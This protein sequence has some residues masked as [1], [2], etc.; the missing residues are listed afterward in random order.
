M[1]VAYIACNNVHINMVCVSNHAILSN[2]MAKSSSHSKHTLPLQ[3]NMMEDFKPEEWQLFLRR[4]IRK[5][6]TK[7]KLRCGELLYKYW[8][9]THSYTST[10]S[11]WRIWKFYEVFFLCHSWQSGVTFAFVLT[12]KLDVK[13]N[14]QTWRIFSTITN[15]LDKPFH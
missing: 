13:F 15:S 12:Q 11:S 2:F 3:D 1:S 14:R 6:N 8:P 7:K 10:S 4:M 9:S 5:S